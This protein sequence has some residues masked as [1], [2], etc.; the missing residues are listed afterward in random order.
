MSKIIF[1]TGVSSGFGRDMASE[2]A[3]AGHTVIG[4]VRKESQIE[5]INNIKQGSTFGYLLDVNDHEKVKEVINDVVN[6]FGR[7]D[8]L[9]NNAGYGLM[10][11]IEATSMDESRMQMETNFFGALAV[12]QAALPHMRKQGSGHIIQFSS[13][14]GLAGSPGLGLYNASKHALEGMSEAL[15]LELKPLNMKVTIVEPGPFRTNWAGGN[16]KFTE[17]SI[18]AYEETAG[19]LQKLITSYNG[20][21]PGNPQK[22]AQ[23][24]LKVIDA[25]NPPLRLLLGKSALDRAK[26]KLD[27]VKKDIAEWEN[28]GLATDY[29]S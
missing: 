27:W 6:R 10:G 16:M 28:V 19:K 17:Q 15:Y 4:T 21:Q 20:N 23:A 2:A 8:V 5:E 9:I 13:I 26:A 25:E 18:E 14:A 1:I 12:T 29:E 22:G 24:V 11:S 7:L 3:Q